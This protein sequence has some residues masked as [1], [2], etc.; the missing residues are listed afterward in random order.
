MNCG[1]PG[2]TQFDGTAYSRAYR[3][4]HMQLRISDGS[5]QIV[6][7]CGGELCEWVSLHLTVINGWVFSFFKTS[8][9]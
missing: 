9:S 5:I 4:I 8:D 2:V 1:A 6:V 7:T 3:S